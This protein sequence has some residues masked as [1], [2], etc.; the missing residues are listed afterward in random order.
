MINANELRI[1]N[2]IQYNDTDLY[3]RVIVTRVHSFNTSLDEEVNG[4]QFTNGYNAFLETV[5][6]TPLTDEWIT[7]F[8][9]ENSK[10]QD[11]FFTKD[12]STGISTADNKFRF[13]QGNF[14]C[15]LVLREI[16]FVHHLQ[17]QYFALTGIELKYETE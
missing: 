4:I 13:I 6:G 12:N 10:T 14:V 2:I 11:K 16:M 17:N 3:K 15:Q 5:N 9:F 7:R 1:G 8:G